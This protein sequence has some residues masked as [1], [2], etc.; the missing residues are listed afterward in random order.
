M[1]LTRVIWEL[2]ETLLPNSPLS[3]DTLNLLAGMAQVVE[4]KK[5]SYEAC[6]GELYAY[7]AIVLEGFARFTYKRETDSRTFSMAFSQ[8]GDPFMSVQTYLSGGPSIFGFQAISDCVILRLPIDELAGIYETHCDWRRWWDKALLEQ[9]NALEF[10]AVWLGKTDARTRY[11]TFC[12]VRPEISRNVPLKY[13]A[14]YLGIAQETL[15]RIR[16]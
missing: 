10:R 1:E 13:I 3:D 6:Q 12:A 2:R 4:R 16:H 8:R 14:D 7:L 5:S 9:L 15:S 11:Q